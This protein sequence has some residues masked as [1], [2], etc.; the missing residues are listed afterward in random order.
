MRGIVLG[1]LIAVAAFAG[2]AR[3]ATPTATTGPATAIGATTATVTGAVNPGG[4]STSWYVEYGTTTGYGKKT[5]S[6]T[7]GSGTSAVSVSADLT[8]LSA[9]TTYHY[10]VV[11]T[12]GAGTSHGGDAVFTTLV[13]P[14]V[15]TEAASKVGTTSAT[16]NGTVDPNGRATTFYFEYGTST[17]YG[18]RT[19]VRAAGSA[20]S[21]QAEAVAISGLQT[22]RTYHFRI[23]ATSDAG[24]A[25]GQDAVFTTSSAPTVTTN[26][27]TPI[28]TKTATLRGSLNPNGLATT[29]WF[30]YGSST[31]YGTKTASHS[32]GAGTSALNESAALSGLKP[33]STYHF[34]LVAQNASGKV[35]GLDRTFTTVGAPAVVTTGA[36]GVGPSTAL[37]TGTLDTKGRSTTWWFEYGTTTKYGLSTPVKSGGSKAGA[38]TVTASI[39][40]LAPAATYHFRLVAKSDGGTGY[41][42]DAT[43]QTAGVSLAA[44]ARQVVYGGRIRLS[45]T[46]PTLQ[47]GEQVV[48]FSQ[49]YGAG[50]AH[51]VATLLTGAGGTWS[52]LA[53]PRIATTY[54]ASWHGGLSPQL[55]ITVHPRVVLTRL[56]DGRFLIRVSGGH[57]F[58]HKSVQLQRR[59]GSR[60]V[61]VRRV[62]LGVRSAAE[63]KATLPRGRSTLRAAFSVN[64]AG[65]GFLGGMSRSVSVRR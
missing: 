58:A 52:Y 7:A 3:A 43:L 24:T 26:D 57:G 6:K 23:V 17:S 22:G 49:P 16:L 64:Q 41:G 18:T 31:S 30:E 59:V 61:T 50:S 55:T 56:K 25:T 62:R 10:R 37:L 63:F 36:Q 39:S 34:R 44:G 19:A 46:V 29:W 65:A 8:G 60:W 20:T 15:V 38:Q 47:P 54:Q 9:G 12:N 11:A 28:G 51:S 48:V 2:D 5:A 42:S 53:R 13:P 32:A 27:A 21:P 40:G 4:Q 35:V 45:G 1:L 14:D 33:G